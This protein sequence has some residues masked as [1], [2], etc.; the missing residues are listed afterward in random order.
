MKRAAILFITL[1]FGLFLA[2]EAFSRTFVTIGTGGVT[3]VYYPTGGAIRSTGAS[4]STKREAT[5]AHHRSRRSSHT[6]QEP[7]PRAA[8]SS[9]R[10]TPAPTQTRRQSPFVL[11]V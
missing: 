10:S 7:T 6:R 11:H 1:L 2:S 4:R 3:G 9:S 8:G 5:G